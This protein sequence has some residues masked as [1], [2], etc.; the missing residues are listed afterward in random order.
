MKRKTLKMLKLKDEALSRNEMRSI[1]A[2]S[3]S[4]GTCG[5][6]CTGIASECFG[7]V[8]ETYAPHQ[9]AYAH[10]NNIC[11]RQMDCCFASCYGGSC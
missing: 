6:V 3:G 1:I 11:Y 7:W 4:G 8:V 2:G 9:D 10:Y 5:S